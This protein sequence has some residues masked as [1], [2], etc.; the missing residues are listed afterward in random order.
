MSRAAVNKCSLLFYTHPY[1]DGMVDRPRRQDVLG[2][3]SVR[4]AHQ[5]EEN[6]NTSI[7][8]AQHWSRQT[9]DGIFRIPPPRREA[10]NFNSYIFLEIKNS[11]IVPRNVTPI[12]WPSIGEY[13]I[14]DFLW[15]SFSSLDSIYI[16]SLKK[17]LILSPGLDNNK[18]QQNSNNSYWGELAH[19]CCCCFH[20]SRI[21]C[22][23]L[24]V[25]RVVKCLSFGLHPIEI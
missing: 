16:C 14:L 20:F 11:L 5:N 10:W 7:H 4:W 22:G 6:K 3:N 21:L 1:K 13:P 15:L 25:W 2:P 17:W 24:A 19:E 23:R 8:Q 12:Q 18:N 9:T